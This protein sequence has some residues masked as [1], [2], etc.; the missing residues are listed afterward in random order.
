MFLIIELITTIVD[1]WAK[2]PLNISILID[3]NNFFSHFFRTSLIFFSLYFSFLTIYFFRFHFRLQWEW[4]AF[5]DFQFSFSSFLLQHCYKHTKHMRNWYRLPQFLRWE[6]NKK[7]LH[8]NSNSSSSIQ[9]KMKKFF[10][11]FFFSLILNSFF[12]SL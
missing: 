7:K 1:F 11:L 4:K 3:I 8:Y 2:F 5:F 6:K 10:F 12:V 9:G